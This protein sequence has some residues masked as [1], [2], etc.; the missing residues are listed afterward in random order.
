MILSELGRIPQADE[1][2]EV[3]ACGYRFTVEEMGERRIEKVR[4]ER[5]PEAEDEE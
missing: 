1:H 5:L 2:P 3:E 4:I